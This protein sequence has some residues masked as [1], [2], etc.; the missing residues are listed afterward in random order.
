MGDVVLGELLRAR[1]LLSGVTPKVA[2]LWIV[3]AEGVSHN[4]VL[5]VAQSL[6]AGGISVEYILNAERLISRRSSAQLQDASRANAEFA[7][8][9]RSPSEAHLLNVRARASDGTPTA[10]IDLQQLQSQ[11][12]EA[13]GIELQKI[14]SALAA[15]AVVSPTA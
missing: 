12:S 11:S 14:R 15:S 5:T 4:T 10:Q 3:A 13:R 1:G 8:L 9:L 2:Q 7:L 6:R